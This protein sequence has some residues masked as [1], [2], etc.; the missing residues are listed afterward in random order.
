MKSCVNRLHTTTFIRISYFT[1]DT[2]FMF[3]LRIRWHIGIHTTKTKKKK[4][5]RY[6]Y[7]IESMKSDL[8]RCHTSYTLTVCL[9]DCLSTPS[10]DS[11]SDDDMQTNLFFLFFSFSW[12]NWTHCTNERATASKRTEQTPSIHEHIYMI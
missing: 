3:Q 1:S 11:R 2:F 5:R 10:I 9:S 7:S 6:I 4:K 8:C 12:L